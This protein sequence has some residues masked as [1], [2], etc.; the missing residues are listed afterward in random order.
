MR[1]GVLAT[2]V[3]VMVGVANGAYGADSSTE[4]V[5]R[6]QT[7]TVTA[8]RRKEDVQTV[9]VAMS[10]VSGDTLK[11]LNIYDPAQLP[12]LSPSLQL[13]GGNDSV[14]A[15]YYSVRGIGTALSTDAGESSVGVMINGVAMS[16]PDMGI[17]QYFDIDRVEVLR[18]PQGFLFGENAS[19]GLINI[20]TVPP[21]V[22]SYE[23]LAHAE[24]GGTTA[25]GGGKEFNGQVAQNIPIG[26]K[27]A[28]RID[29][30]CTTNP[31][32]IR[33]ILPGNDSNLGEKEGGARVEYLWQP[34]D[35]LD[36]YAIGD[37]A[38]ESGLGVAA[39][40]WGI[41]RPGGFV[42]PLNLAAGINATLTNTDVAADGKD[43]A[44]FRAGG[45][46]LQVAYHLD[47][48]LDL[49]NIAAWRTFRQSIS[50]DLDFL[51]ENEFNTNTQSRT[52][53][54]FSDELR[55]SSPSTGLVTYQ[56]GLYYLTARYSQYRN[57]SGRLEGA[58]PTLPPGDMSV[59]GGVDLESLPASNYAVYGQGAAHVTDRLRVIAGGRYTYDEISNTAQ[60]LCNGVLVC[61]FNQI[62]PYQHVSDTNF[63]W[64]AGLQYDISSGSMAY[65]TFARGYKG[66]AINDSNQATKPLRPEIPTSLEFGLKSTL[67]DHRLIVDAD[68]F[69]TDFRDY[70]A[71]AFDRVTFARVLANAGKLRTEGAE[72]DL[73]AMPASGLTLTA[74]LM[75]DDAYY[76]SFQGQP[77]YPLEPSGTGRNR[78]DA[79][80]NSDASGNRLEDAP[81][82]SGSVTGSYVHPI[83]SSY[84]GFIRADYH[85]RSKVNFSAD[86]DPNTVEPGYGILGMSFGVSPSSGSWQLSVFARNLADRRFLSY[87]FLNPWVN[88][89]GDNALGGDYWNSFGVDSFRT[90][91]VALDLHF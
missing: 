47:G 54:Q 1:I 55:L 28:L 16:R 22:G 70:Q 13:E 84:F 74:G 41:V 51:P 68:V 61:L 77:C 79:S 43:D 91:G 5:T 67:L 66:P 46:Q 48:G 32:V 7:V 81:A 12:L 69:H 42:Q 4:A 50:A 6:L 52:E 53:K 18:G 44:H 33:N 63:S 59:F 57:L 85:Y 14:G 38:A 87:K 3:G 88:F 72:L 26:D 34:N 36:I 24:Y 45:A 49:T 21:K 62:L 29:G 10:V 35:R 37:Y 56:A 8:E 31:G 90:V 73:R 83:S 39:Q 19:A 23:S 82:W 25:A 86:G 2:T 65:F 71:T 64:R 30:F 76:V 78:C 20:T 15:A 27:Q 11:Q 17:V 40:S 80:G 9:P 89:V 75:Y 60:S 58:V